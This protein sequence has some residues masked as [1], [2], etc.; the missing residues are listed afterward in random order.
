MSPD[1]RA[2]FVSLVSHHLL[3]VG[4]SAAKLTPAGATQ[5]LAFARRSRQARQAPSKGACVIGPPRPSA[6][7]P[8]LE[9]HRPGIF[10]FPPHARAASRRKTQ[11]S[12]ILP[13]TLPPFPPPP[14]I[15]HT[16]SRRS[17]RRGKHCV[18]D[19]GSLLKSR[20]WG[21]VILSFPLTPT[22]PTA[23]HPKLA[24]E[25]PG[26]PRFFPL[27]YP[28]DEPTTPPTLDDDLSSP[29]LYRP[30]TYLLGNSRADS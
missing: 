27:Q 13:S 15:L 17:S 22:E 10:Y 4:D 14:Y 18:P 25:L 20:S 26:C 1:N 23:C 21:S 8:V 30:L 9:A 6:S 5:T 19:P 29:D 7:P 3:L 12:P 24:S 16:L 11:S 28:P 2:L